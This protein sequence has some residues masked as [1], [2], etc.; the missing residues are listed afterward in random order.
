MPGSSIEGKELSMQWIRIL[1]PET[2][3]DVGAGMGWYEDFIKR[4]K[5]NY[6]KLD[7]IEV[8]EP[9]I[10]KYNLKARYDNVFNID[11]REWNN[12]KYDLII[13]GDILEHMTKEEAIKLW[14]NISKQAR[15]AIISIPIVHYPQGHENGN[16]Y[17]EHIKDDWSSKEVLESF[18]NITTHKEFDVVGIYLAT[19][20]N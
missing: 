1:K 5:I 6:K 14:D 13:L 7:A 8:W 18:K 17:E 11:A 4:N 2:I 20:N 10:E 3:L 19:F 16:P 9:Y 15:F 12:W